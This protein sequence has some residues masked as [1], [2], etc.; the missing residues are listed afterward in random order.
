MLIYISSS[1][2]SQLFTGVTSPWGRKAPMKWMKAWCWE[3]TKTGSINVIPQGENDGGNI[4][5]S[6]P[7]VTQSSLGPGSELYFIMIII[8]LEYG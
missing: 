3:D 5:S 2:S 7:S 8:F 1:N 4:S 6:S